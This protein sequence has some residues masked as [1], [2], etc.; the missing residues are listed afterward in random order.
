MRNLLIVLSGPSGVGK[1]TI[2]K[3]LLKDGNY[4]LSVSCTT[5][6]PRA[7]ERDGREYFFLSKEKFL[8]MIESGGLLEYSN[9]F[10]NYYGTP[11]EFVENKLKSNDVILEIDVDGAL[12]VKKAYPQALLIMILPP[13]KN[14]LRARLVGRETESAEI[15]DERLKRME[16]EVSL[17]DKYDYTVINDDLEAAVKEIENI[18][19]RQKGANII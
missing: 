7:G 15:I 5:R 9:H 2:V 6:P 19:K 13:D 18:I 4:C 16:Y 17:A 14:T 8:S 1:G 3:K 11:R 12:N 10:G